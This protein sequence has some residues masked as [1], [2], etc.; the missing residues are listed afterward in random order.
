[1]AFDSKIQDIKKALDDILLNLENHDDTFVQDK[2]GQKIAYYFKDIINCEEFDSEFLSDHYDHIYMR[3]GIL[4]SNGQGTIDLD[5]IINNEYTS[6]KILHTIQKIHRVVYF[7]CQQIQRKT[8][9]N[10]LK[11]ARPIAITYR[12]MQT[13]QKTFD[14]YHYDLVVFYEILHILSNRILRRGSKDKDYFA[15]VMMRLLVIDGIPNFWT[16]CRLSRLKMADIYKVHGIPYI[17]VNMKGGGRSKVFKNFPI[18]NESYEMLLTRTRN[19]KNKNKYFF[20]KILHSDY[21]RGERKGK[22][23]RRIMIEA[24]I[25]QLLSRAA[26]H[27]LKSKSISVAKLYRLIAVDMEVSGVPYMTICNA[28]NILRGALIDPPDTVMRNRHESSSALSDIY[29]SLVASIKQIPKKDKVKKHQ[30]FIVNIV[31]ELMT[32]C[33]D[34][35]QGRN[36]KI[37][38]EMMADFF[39]SN[40]HVTFATILDYPTTI[41]KQILLKVPGK[42]LDQLSVPEWIELGNDIAEDTSFSVSRR[43]TAKTAYRRIYRYLLKNK[44]APVIEHDDITFRIS[45]GYASGDVLFPDKF[46]CLIDGFPVQTKIACILSFYGGARCEEIFHLT[47]KSFEDIFVKIDVSKI[48][49]SRRDVPIKW[50]MPATK[51]VF[52][53]D[54]LDEL[55]SDYGDTCRICDPEKRMNSPNSLSARVLKLFKKQ[56]EFKSSLHRLRHDFASWSLVRYYMITDGDFRSAAMNGQLV[57]SFPSSHPLF[58]EP[59]LSKFAMAIGG[60]D[61]R[62]Q[63][64]DN[65]F[66]HGRPDDMVYLSRFLGHIN[67]FTTLENYTNSLSWIQH[68]YLEKR[69]KRIKRGNPNSPIYD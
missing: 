36:E 3:C 23:D 35:V 11:S 2:S 65:G 67:R 53:M 41:S 8:N 21:I 7:L 38:L 25:K 47:P 33:G 64:R 10:I 60:I 46:D 63:L 42:S 39:R 49:S 34:D 50:L 44:R 37:G 1:M 12:P 24:L 14:L 20:P 54:Y 40:P 69:L 17:R 68:Y 43:A 57:D 56:Q 28:R 13:V 9:F 62:N 52:L 61:W 31:E 58:S 55:R 22:T 19:I 32:Q 18:T 48:N 16:D 59:E 27:P 66:C 51:Y 15:V 4:D 29:H 26:H 5:E 45:K 30:E 6:D